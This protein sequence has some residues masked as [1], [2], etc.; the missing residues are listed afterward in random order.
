MRKGVKG[1]VVNLKGAGRVIV[2]MA[3]GGS[4]VVGV[5]CAPEY[6]V[7]ASAQLVQEGS[8]TDVTWEAPEN[9]RIFVVNST[10]NQITYTGPVN[11]A[12]KVVIDLA[13][14]LIEV[15]GRPVVS[16]S[17]SGADTYQ[18]HFMADPLLVRS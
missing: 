14:N 1:N 6:S 18:I 8:N 9:G 12:D 4:A 7:P 15:G 11:R 16:G 3:I 13:N 10:L 17:L 2:A 5:G